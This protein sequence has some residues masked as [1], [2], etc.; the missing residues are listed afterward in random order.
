MGQYRP[1]IFAAVVIVHECTGLGTKRFLVV[2]HYRNFHIYPTNMAVTR[3]NH[4][5][6]VKPNTN[7]LN[8]DLSSFYGTTL[9]RPRSSES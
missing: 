7:V 2:K 9:L 5:T 1:D 6:I 4:D 3:E 8:I